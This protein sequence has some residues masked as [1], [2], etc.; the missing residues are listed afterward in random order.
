M[1]IHEQ[2]E[3]MLKWLKDH[4][5]HQNNQLKEAANKYH[6][7]IKNFKGSTQ[8]ETLKNVAKIQKTISDRNDQIK[9]L[10]S[11]LQKG[12]LSDAD[13]QQ[14]HQEIDRL[15]KQNEIDDQSIQTQ[16]NMILEKLA[17]IDHKFKQACDE[18]IKGYQ[19]KNHEILDTVNKVVSSQKQV[20][21]LKTADK[22]LP[23]SAAANSSDSAPK[24]KKEI[25]TKTEIPV[26]QENASVILSTPKS[27]LAKNS[28]LD[29][30]IERH[31]KD[32]LSMKRNDPEYSIMK[33]ELKYLKEARNLRDIQGTSI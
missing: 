17:E 3:Q 14:K 31:E 16:L 12:N 5:V 19:Q 26:G 18:I 4:N 1:D 9:F 30:I 13:R 21:S 8:A 10:N 28:I 2:K 24:P 7:E 23:S 29:K 22:H 32:L 6:K 11:K 27:T 20:F 15:K 33:A 25:K